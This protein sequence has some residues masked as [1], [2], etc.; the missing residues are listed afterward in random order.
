[1]ARQVGSLC[2]WK[3]SQYHSTKLQRKLGVDSLRTEQKAAEDVMGVL[4]NEEAVDL[5]ESTTIEVASTTD[6]EWIL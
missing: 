2:T 4:D 6:P 3:T 1:M 5:E